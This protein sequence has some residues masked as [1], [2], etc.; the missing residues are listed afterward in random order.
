MT[1]AETVTRLRATFDSG[2]T[3][4]LAWRLEQ[5]A[6]LTTMIEER[7]DEFTAALKADLGKPALEAYMTETGFLLSELKVARKGLRSWARPRKVKTA[8]AAQ[9]GSAQIR[10]EP[11]GVVLNIA[12]WNYPFHLAIAPL[13]GSIAAGNC[14][15]VKPSELAP[16]TSAAVA[17]WLPEYVDADAVAVVEGGVPEATA[18]L[19]QPFDHVFFTGGLGVGRIVMEAAARHLCPVTLELGGKSPCIVDRAA[20]IRTAARR[21]VWGKFTNTGQTCV[22]PDYVLV[23][24]DVAE[25]LTESIVRYTRK[26]Y[27]DDP[28]SCPDYGRIVNVRHHR[29]LCALLDS[30]KV[31]IGGEAD[32]AEKFIAPT[33]LTDVSPDAPVM[34]EEIFGPILPILV[35]A[36]LDEAIAFVNARPRPLALYVFSADR[37][38]REAV[39]ERTCSGGACVNDTLV[40]LGVPTLPFG[41]V[42]PSGMGAYHGKASFDLLSHHRS[43][44][45]RATFVDP[46][47]RYPPFN[48]KKLA[49]IRRFL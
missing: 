47:A 11:L 43:V 15:V 36:D 3:R 48:E 6:A 10:S 24:A 19:E 18:L 34:Q 26:F 14:T 7:E 38:A 35:V 45:T 20:D 1:A 40:H 41:G 27:G 2:R 46:P 23:H 29:R 42:G 8:L 49:L 21:I 13:I 32:E 33:V 4:P 12:P 44:L 31:A 30:G 5:L 28:R 17:K 37:R 22:A 16:A 39:I 9:P 25:A